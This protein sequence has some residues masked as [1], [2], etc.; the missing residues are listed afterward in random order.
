MVTFVSFF[1]ILGNLHSDN[2][3]ALL[4]GNENLNFPWKRMTEISDLI[5]EGN[6]ESN[7]IL[8]ENI[9]PDNFIL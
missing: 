7:I 3:L 5:H 9:Y 4:S 6:K 1:L 2:I 8:A